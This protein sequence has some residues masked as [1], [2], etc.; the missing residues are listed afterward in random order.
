MDWPNAL[1][2]EL[3]GRRCI[4]FLGAGASAGCLSLDGLRRPPDWKTFLEELKNALPGAVDKTIID[5]RLFKEKYLDAAEIILCKISGP[6]FSRIIRQLFIQPHYQPCNIHQAVLAIDPKLVITT[7]FD[8]IYDNY[9]RTGDANDGYNVCKYYETHLVNDLRSPVRL[10]VKAHGCVSNA[11][12]II[13]TRSHYFEQRQKFGTFYNVL[14]ALFIT[15]TLLFIGYSLSDPDIQLLLENSNIA[16]PSEHKHYAVIPDNIPS[17]IEEASAKAY[18]V[19]FLK[20]QA[21]NYKELED[22]LEEL[23]NQVTQFRSLNP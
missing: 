14:D 15:N 3:A 6:D 22:A 4:I 17:D 19:H 23:K 2:E 20:F 1:I 9:C 5:D 13:L 11:Q 8:D 16:A 18:N 7:N 12:K 21:G 10:I